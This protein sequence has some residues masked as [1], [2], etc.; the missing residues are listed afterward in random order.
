M[1]GD[2]RRRR[3]EQPV[4]ARAEPGLAARQAAARSTRRAG[5]VEQLAQGLRNPWRFSFTP[6]G[7]IV[8]ADVGQGAYEEVN[9]GLAANYGWPCREGMHAF[10]PDGRAVDGDELQD[11]VLEKNHGGGDLFCSITGGFVVRD[12]GLPTL[13]GRYIYGDYCAAAAALLR[14]REPGR[15]RRRRPLGAVAELVRRGRLQPRARRV[16]ERPGVPARGRRGDPVRRSDA[17]RPRPRRHADPTPTPPPT[18]D[19]DHRHATPRPRRRRPDAHADADRHADTHATPRRPR[20]R[21][22]RQPRPRRHRPRPPR[23]RR[24]PRRTPP[25]PRPQRLAAPRPAAPSRRADTR[26]AP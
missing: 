15:R 8:I 23:P 19:T 26:P 13:V 25:P 1:A 21:R 9:V 16:A 17:R 10:R 5:A 2:R 3:R 6:G 24:P 14:A 11:P 12:P 18:A 4:R 7:E 22:R 20:R